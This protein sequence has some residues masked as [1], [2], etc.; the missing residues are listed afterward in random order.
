MKS[1]MPGQAPS[2]IKHNGLSQA[3]TERATY[4]PDRHIPKVQIAKGKDEELREVRDS[5]KPEPRGMWIG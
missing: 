1:V 2:P 3:S 4:S 5:R